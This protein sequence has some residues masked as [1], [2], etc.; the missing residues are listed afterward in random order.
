MVT[1]RSLK[2]AKRSIRYLPPFF[3][4]NT[5]DYKIVDL[6]RRMT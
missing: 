6:E 2:M 5:K 3:T 1:Y 4:F